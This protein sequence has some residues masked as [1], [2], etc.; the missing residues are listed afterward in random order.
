MHFFV[1]NDYVA[2]K[3]QHTAAF[4]LTLTLISAVVLLTM[5]CFQGI[6]IAKGFTFLLFAVGNSSY[7]VSPCETCSRCG[8]N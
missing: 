4:L 6:E 2:R 7:T 8:S 1:D 5:I 3:T